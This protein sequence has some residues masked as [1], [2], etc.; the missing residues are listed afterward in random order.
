[1]GTPIFGT[2]YVLA[3]TPEGEE[4]PNII[5]RF[6]K[7]EAFCDN[8]CVWTN[9]HPDCVIGQRKP[10]TNEEIE[11]VCTPLGFAQLSPVEIARA[12]EKAH[13]IE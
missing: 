4:H 3:P 11:R 7:Q 8:H 10:L 12:I 1:M 13:G 2:R 5:D 9:H 6:V